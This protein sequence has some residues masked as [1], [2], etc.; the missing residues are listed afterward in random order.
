M[1]LFLSESQVEQLL[2]MP[3]V[4]SSVE[5]AFK[6]E[7]E[8]EA[9]NS[10]R[11]RSRAPSAELNV[12]HAVL[13]YLGRG[14]LKCYMS[15]QRGTRFVFILFDMQDSSP[16]AVMGADLLGRFRTGAAS[17]VATK[18]LYGGASAVLAVFGSGKQAI[19][20]VRAIAA[21]THLSAVRVWSPNKAHR[22][23]FARKLGEAGFDASASDTPQAAAKGADVGTTITSSNDPFLDLETVAG[24][25]H[26]NICGGNNP[27]RSEIASEA[28]GSFLTVAVDDLPQAKV[29]YGDLIQ[30]AAAGTFSWDRA[31]E[32]KDVVAGKVRPRGK[33]LFKSGGAALEDVAVASMVFDKAMKEGI[34]S[35]SDVELGF[36]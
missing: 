30:A 25:Q 15:S 16:L 35:T 12:M 11:T 5:E 28:V 20:Q 23:S 18:Y 29:E 36:A 14:G 21:V 1:T 9:V 8:G 24:L 26:L 19:T 13:T 22:E 33:T 3:E 7:A 32:L 2:E 31:V 10:S 6:R 4:V 17:G 27:D 34:F